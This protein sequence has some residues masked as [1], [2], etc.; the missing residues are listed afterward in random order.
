VT[1]YVVDPETA[2]VEITASSTL[3]SIR[4]RARRASGEID[5]AGDGTITAG[6][7]E[8]AVRDLS[9]G[10]PLLDRETRRRID[11]RSHPH[12]IGVVVDD[13][14]RGDVHHTRGS[15]AFHDVSRDVEGELH[16]ELASPGAI[17]VRGEQRFDVR[18]WGL[19]PPRLLALKVAPDITVRIRIEARR[20]DS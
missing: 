3:H 2:E 14:V 12:I 10:N 1:R 4:G 19:E 17:V 18:D 7:L 9:W 6:R 13:E 5:L 15:I 16:V 8:V 20:A 11:D